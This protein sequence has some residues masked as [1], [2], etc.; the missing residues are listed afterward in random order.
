VSLVAVAGRHTRENEMRVALRQ[1]VEESAD[2]VLMQGKYDVDSAEELVADF[3]SLLVERLRIKDR[4]LS[5]QV[6]IA[7][8]DS[9]KGLLSVHVAETYTHPNGRKGLAET[10]ATILLEQEEKKPLHR[11]DFCI[12]EELVALASEAD[13][14]I[15]S[16][17]KT[18]LL[19]EGELLQA[20]SNP[21]D[22]G[23]K[24]F[25]AWSNE[26][27]AILTTAELKT[28]KAEQSLT[29]RAVYN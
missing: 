4:N 9:E 7:G 28:M 22:F 1:A 15:P 6:D 24:Y 16:E 23:G 29:L 10:E 27:G 26:D 17:Y 3:T 12:P 19:E 11:V 14:A 5:L 21:P 8:V 25:V 2:Q 18:Y 20:P 13:I